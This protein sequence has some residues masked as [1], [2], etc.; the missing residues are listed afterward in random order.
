MTKNNRGKSEKFFDRVSKKMNKPM[1]LKQTALKTIASTS[2]FLKTD[3]VVLD[4]G[5]GPGTITNEI[6]ENVKMIHAID[7]SSG[8]IEVA[9][10]KSEERK[11]KNVNFTQSTIFDERFES[12]SFDV[13]LTFN[14]LHYIEDTQKIMQRVNELLKPGGVFISATACLRERRSFLSILMV[15]LTKI[16]IIPAMRFFKISELENIIEKGK[17]RIMETKNLS[18]LPDCFIVAKKT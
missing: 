13:I 7:L 3:Y 4:F 10:G 1:K 9:K 12:E 14:V 11:I 18:N 16:R 2:K 6:A 17:F 15:L 8:M 5:C